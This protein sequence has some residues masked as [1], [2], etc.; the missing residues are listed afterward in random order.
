MPARRR[1]ATSSAAALPFADADPLRVRPPVTAPAALAALLLADGRFP[2]GGHVHSAG[3]ESAVAD[4]RV[5]G[6][7][8]LEDHL[9]G[10]LWTVGLTEAALA[11]ATTVRL[12]A[13]GPEV[14]RPDVI[15]P[16]VIRPDVIRPDVVGRDVV[17]PDVVGSPVARGHDAGEVTA[18]L[19]AA[20]AALDAEADARIP[21]PGLREASRRLGRQLVRVA[22]RCWPAPV[23]ALAA[24]RHPRGLHQPVALGAVGMAA[25]L[26]PEDV[27]RLNVHHA[28]TTPAQA[29]VRLLGLDPFAVAA[30]TARLGAVGE[31]VVVAALAAAAG[32]LADLP[33]RAG[34]VVDVAAAEHRGWDVR[35]FAT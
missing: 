27:A 6:L 10:R 24:D 7:D 29:A 15:R 23:L 1:N 35:L 13:G 11:A 18:A 12:T 21:V 22:G 20:I 32:P 14:V 8:S 34:P 2:V 3:V 33:A 28:L 26:A 19:T 25:G 17:R 31:A 4:G 9:V 30:L 5:R 16:D